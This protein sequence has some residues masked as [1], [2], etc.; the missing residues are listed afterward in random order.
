MRKKIKRTR[1]ICRK[2]M[3]N[4]MYVVLA[5]V[6]QIVQMQWKN[7]TI[8]LCNQKWRNYIMFCDHIISNMVYL[9][10]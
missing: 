9:F 2:Q 7:Q 10:S 6:S 3:Y 4:G 1:N 8:L 5:R